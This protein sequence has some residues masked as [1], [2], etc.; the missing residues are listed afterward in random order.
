MFFE[1]TIG[2]RLPGLES[3]SKDIN[4]LECIQRRIC[5]KWDPVHSMIVELHWPTSETRIS[6]YLCI[7]AFYLICS[8]KDMLYLTIHTAASSYTCTYLSYLRSHVL[9]L[10]KPYQPYQIHSL[11]SERLV[12]YSTYE[13]F[14]AMKQHSNVVTSSYSI[15]NTLH[16]T[17]IKHCPQ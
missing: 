17:H 6:M 15:N 3:L 8:I 10:Y 5:V 11:H 1:T 4:V 14:E 9:S 13:L 2:I 16:S 12:N 7:F